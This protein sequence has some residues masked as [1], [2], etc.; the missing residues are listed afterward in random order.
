MELV[1]AKL[2][3]KKG[4]KRKKTDKWITTRPYENDLDLL[5]GDSK[6]IL[7]FIRNWQ[8]HTQLYP[9]VAKTYSVI[10]GGGKN[11]L[12]YIRI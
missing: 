12:S 6:N 1:G 4:T 8:K 2:E 11:I 10:S 9:E 7:S 5:F 3:L